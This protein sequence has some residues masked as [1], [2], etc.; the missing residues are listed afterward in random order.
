MNPT[1]VDRCVCRN[2]TFAELWQIHQS[3][4]ASLRQLQAQTGCGT[5]CGMCLPYIKVVLKTGRVRLPV[6]GTGEGSD[7]T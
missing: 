5:V 4:G 7:E 3:T 6:M 1:P 2:V